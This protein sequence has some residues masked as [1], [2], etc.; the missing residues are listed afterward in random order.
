M[1]ANYQNFGHYITE[2]WSNE[3]KEIF[4]F[5]EHY[6][7]QEKRNKHTSLLDVGCATGELIHFLSR[8]HPEFQ[9]TGVD[10]FDD[11]IHQ[12]QELQPEKKFLKAS[13]L[14]LPAS[15]EQ[16]F[17]VITVVGVL[18]IFDEEEL[19]LFFNNLFRA[20]RSNAS[21]YIL[22]PFNEYGVDCEIKHRKRQQGKRGNWEKGWNI[23]SKETIIEHIENH[24]QSWSFHPFKLPFNL[25]QKEDPIR[26]WTIET[27][28]NKRQLTNG[29][30][31]LVDH[32]LLKISV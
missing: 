26:T 24:A 21:I 11:L 12:C 5:L 7:S 25:S 23:F 1:S 20:C 2:G 17:D 16:Q 8:H 31:L 18:T 22:S 29:L 14:E 15:L 9:F 10:I 28:S 30:K 13:I 32:Y 6:L 19:P 3:P 4:K 27:E